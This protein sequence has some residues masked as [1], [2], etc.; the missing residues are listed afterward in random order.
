MIHAQRLTKSYPM[1][2]RVLMALDNVSLHISEGEYAAIVGPSGS[3][4]STLMHILG[5]LDSPT[6]GRYRLHGRDVSALPSAE[7]AKVRGEE[8]GFVF[9]GF[10]LIPR[11]TAIENVALPMV[12][13]G[14]E[15]KERLIRAQ[16]LLE[17]VGLGDRLRHKPSQRS[18]GQQ[19]R[20]AIA[21]ARARHPAVL[22][23][24]EPTGSL[25]PASTG[26]VLA[27]L[28]QLHREGRTV[29]VI[30]HDAKVAARAGR[31]LQIRDGRLVGDA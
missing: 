20:G 16:S 15:A 23:A 7:L 19:Q 27:L 12:L 29:V 11:L 30:T 9:Q 17:R 8:I 6:S 24:D 22:R 13:Q 2:G 4:K 26:E 28:D 25:D 1:E 5:C 18:G 10:Q 21:R 3:G 14:M 31:Q